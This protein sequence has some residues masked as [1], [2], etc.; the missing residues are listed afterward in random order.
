ML[1]SPK[2]QLLQKWVPLYS[3]HTITRDFGW[4][5]HHW[6]AV[7]MSGNNCFTLFH[8]VTF[9]CR[10]F[11]LLCL[12]WQPHISPCEGRHSQIVYFALHSSPLC[13]CRYLLHC[14]CYLLKYYTEPF[15]GIYP[16]PLLFA[17]LCRKKT[18][19]PTSAIPSPVCHHQ[20]TFWIG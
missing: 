10:A 9:A 8:W 17:K 2:W 1:L 15:G 13:L 18:L 3:F 19:Q 11:T 16:R 12:I 7:H 5:F 6:E 4:H 14:Y 20:D